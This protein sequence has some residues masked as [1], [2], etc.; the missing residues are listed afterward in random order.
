MSNLFSYKK[1]ATKEKEKKRE[2]ERKKE[3]KKEGKKKKKTSTVKQINF[4]SIDKLIQ[5][6]IS[7]FYFGI[8]CNMT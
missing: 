3:R 7:Y 4:K 2:K 6:Q 8:N 1:I 5:E